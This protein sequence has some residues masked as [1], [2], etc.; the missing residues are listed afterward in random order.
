[1]A[2]SS[3]D[4][5]N[6]TNLNNQNISN[7]TVTSR[8]TA[9]SL[10]G[11][12][13][14][15]ASGSALAPSLAFQSGSTDSSGL[16]MVSGWPAPYRLGIVPGAGQIVCEFVVESE[17]SSIRLIEL[18]GTANATYNT[19]HIAYSGTSWGILFDASGT[20]GSGS[21]ANRLHII[22][23]KTATDSRPAS[24]IP[25]TIDADGVFFKDVGISISSQLVGRPSV[26]S[27][28]GYLYTDSTSSLYWVNGS[29]VSTLLA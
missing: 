1:M 5:I 24:W 13:V 21:S 14:L 8:L 26:A 22:R 15:A 17:T 6:S 29:G 23:S 16:Y 7:L 3:G 10:V 27:S 11:D 18:Y 28:A 25:M 2:W 20:T 9:A 4:S 12:R 19:P